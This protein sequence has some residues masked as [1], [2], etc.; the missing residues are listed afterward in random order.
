[1]Q[2]LENLAWDHIYMSETQRGLPINSHWWQLSYSL[3]AWRSAGLVWSSN[4]IIN[5]CTIGLSWS[6]H[7]FA[8]YR[9]PEIKRLFF[10]YFADLMHSFWIFSY[11]CLWKNDIMA[12]GFQ[13][14]ACYVNGSSQIFTPYFKSLWCT[15]RWKEIMKHY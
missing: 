7:S 5:W 14:F 4:R 2:N 6:W 1:M 3:S 12:F 13:S 15:L 10:L 11:L 8:I 9:W